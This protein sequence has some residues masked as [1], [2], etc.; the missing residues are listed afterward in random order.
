IV[1][2][3]SPDVL[4]AERRYG[5]ISGACSEAVIRTY[6]LR[7]TVSDAIDKVLLNRL[8]GLPILFI[9]AWLVFRFTFAFSR[10]AANGIQ[11][12]VEFLGTLI[13]RLL[14]SHSLIQS[15]IV[16][17]VI[18]GLG[19]VLVFVPTI[20]SLFLAIAFL[21]YSGYMAR[22][23][24]IM[25]SFM[26][27]IGLHGRSFIPMLLGFG[28]NVPAI[29][30][31]R[32]IEDRKDR[33][34]TI[35][36]NP[37][38]SCGARL[39]VYVL[40]IGAFF[41]ETMAGNVL[42]SLYILGILIA[43]ILAK[44]FRKYILPGES[45]PFVMELPPYRLPT[46]KGL[47]IHM[48]E[49]GVLYLKKA[50]TVI[51]I[52]C[53]VLWFLSN[54]PRDN[55]YSKNYNILIEQAQGSKEII[56]ALKTEITADK[57]KNSYAGKLGNLIT[58]FFQPLGFAD[59]KVSMA[60]LG[61]FVAKEVIIGTLSTL[62]AVGEGEVKLQSLRRMI[63]A[64]RRGDGSKLFTPLS[65]YSFMIFVLL[66]LP[67]VAVLAVIRKETNS[68]KWPLFTVFYTTS[69]AWLVSFMFY[70]GGRLLGL[71]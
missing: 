28:C 23:A 39:P 58:P 6:E 62:Y 41:P 32:T 53:L 5:F 44:I 11:S 55:D 37:F 56:A 50:G 68:W 63:Q 29:M 31:T 38:I 14:P 66:Y 71:G 52:S 18:A 19:G 70:Q 9:L 17:G 15:L 65:A 27:R 1:F 21:E 30:S 33:L 7:H 60:L 22:A 51:F 48:W 42:F 10:P 3:D 20:F 13:S 47:L 61:G 35:L 40:F 26:H 54:F 49:R 59:W 64:D 46:L 2:G 25:D 43:I 16:D 24:F 67:C 8:I 45:V 69:V 57:L 36:V 12:A 4:L 34:V